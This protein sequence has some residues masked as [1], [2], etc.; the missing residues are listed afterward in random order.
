MS[1]MRMLT[2]LVDADPDAIAVLDVLGGTR[3]PVSRAELLARSQALAAELHDRGVS[4]GDCIAVWLPN[5]SDALCW[6]FAASAIG[7]HVIGIN[8]RYNVDEVAHVLDRARPKA[9]ALAHD[10]HGLDLI[11]RLRQAV[12]RTTAAPPVL[13]IVAGPGRAEV[14]DPGRYDVGAGVWI[15]RTTRGS[16][17]APDLPAV[18][19]D[20]LAVA[21]TTSGSTGRAKLP[22]HRESAVEAHAL[23][24]ARALGLHG[25]DV[26]VCALPVSGVFGFCTAMAALAGGACCLMFPVF[27]AD[28]VVG[29]MSEA[30]ATHVVGGDDMLIRLVESA[31]RDAPDLAAWRW[32]GMADFNGRAREIAEWLLGRYG[33]RTTGVYG[34][35]EVFALALMW[36]ENEASPRR[37]GGGGR[38]VA[39]D[40]RFRAVDPVSQVPVAPGENGELQLRGPNVV[41]AYLGDPGA[42]TASVTHDGWFQ[43][44]DLATI[45][46]DGGVDYLCRM[47]DVLRLRGFLVEPA[48]IELRLIQHP[49]VENAKVV[50]V[51]SADG[52]HRAVG[53]VVPVAGSDPTP[54]ELRGW[55][56]KTLASFK[57]PAEIRVIG[58]MPTTTGTNGTK[59]KAA[60][61]REWAKHP[62]DPSGR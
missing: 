46:G 40:I 51:R 3:Q 25:G 27:D 1:L 30:G 4:S 6:Q 24:D 18:P 33:T 49:M 11:T 9:I 29:H 15:P 22:A 16:A 59:V 56:A 36:P 54:E 57:V 32:L 42:L 8:T 14:T 48:E 2:D 13:A 21:F 31:R 53:F 62:N 47:G 52:S 55:C 58:E 37:W 19:G 10:F 44:G 20:P 61:L 23:A 26:V 17:T 60:V 43:T 45:T 34:S 35:S 38:P 12:G 50:G 7:G 41:D 28:A 5:W 39:R